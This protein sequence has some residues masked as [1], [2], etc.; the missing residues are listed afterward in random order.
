MMRFIGKAIACGGRLVWAALA[1]AAIS[2]SA[3]AQKPGG[4]LK[5]PHGDSPASM[6]I[7]EE[8]TI[9]SEGPMMA[10]FNNLVMFDQHIPQN[11]LDTIVPDLAVE[12]SWSEDGTT[13]TFKLR[14]GVKW[15]DGKP[16][17]ANDVKC[18]WDL[19][20]GKGTE[21][22]RI[23]PRKSWYQNLAEVTINGDFEA[24]FHL[25]RPQPSFIG[26]LASGWSPVYPCHVTPREMRQHPIGT[27]PFKFVEFKPNES[28]KL[29]RN[30]E[31]WKPGRPY[32]DGIEYTIIRNA[33]TW[34]LAL[35][36][37]QFDRTGPGFVPISLLKE[38]ENQAPEMSCEIASWNTSRT[39]IINRA[40]PPFD[41]PELRRAIMLAL[42]RKAFIDIIGEGQGEIGA[43]M[44]PLPNGVWGM[45]ADVLRTL[46]GYDLDIAKNREQAKQIM[47]KLGYGP[48]RRLAVTMTTRNVAAYRDPAVILIDQLKEIYIDGTLKA[49]DTT[50]W[51][52]TVMRKEYTLAFTVTET[53][54]DDPDQMFY[55]NY[56]C[57]SERN[58]TG[59]CNAEVDRLIDQQSVETDAGKR[60]QIVWQI[61]K[62]L[63]EDGG[64]PIIFH[65]RSATCS[66]SQVK[67]ITVGVNSPYNLW[68]MEDAWLDR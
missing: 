58:Y 27:G 18:T 29:T 36:A 47:Q 11:R 4:I 68:R 55:E 67:G 35:G 17:T 25:K 7:H 41:N 19:L 57:G 62:D 9:V 43:T 14:Q 66:Y 20:L 64:R 33:S 28:I 42:D 15:H 53:G 22:L 5:I 2:A 60:R 63:A 37:H 13:L 46:P 56:F 49:I 54:L 6:S 8:S 1:L 16:F 65:P 12:W 51:Y 26:L 44:Q 10:V 31:Y 59:Y 40:V 39:A 24:S 32:L 23:N 30:P 48:D 38:I 45:P 61:E 34:I 3:A 21:K 50:Q 52:P